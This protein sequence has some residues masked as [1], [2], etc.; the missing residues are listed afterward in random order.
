MLAR[1]R[2]PLAAQQDQVDYPDADTLPWL[3][4]LAERMGEQSVFY[5]DWMQPGWLPTRRQRWLATTGLGLAAA[6]TVGLAAGLLGGLAYGLAYGLA[7]GLLAGLA[8]RLA[9]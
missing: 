2:A 1:P 6:L 8:G 5:P 9:A 4:W 7:V 3:G